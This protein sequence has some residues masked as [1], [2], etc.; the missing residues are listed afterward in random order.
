[1]HFRRK[2]CPCGSSSKESAC[3][4]G[5]TG[6]VGLIPGSGRSPRGGNGNTLQYSCL[7]NPMDRGA[8]WA[9][10]YGVT[11]NQV[12]LRTHTLPIF[13]RF[14]QA[15]RNLYLHNHPPPRGS[16]AGIRKK[17]W[18]PVTQGCA[19]H[20]RVL[21]EA[22]AWLLSLSKFFFLYLKFFS[23]LHCLQPLYFHPECYFTVR[24]Q[25]STQQRQKW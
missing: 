11:K 20:D 7:G 4:A 22:S 6:D 8:W 23:C 12:Q 9:T 5:L 17:L 14:P 24:L 13:C 3:N 1:M 19:L 21:C 10:K 2:L 15:C 16:Q 25:K 18:S